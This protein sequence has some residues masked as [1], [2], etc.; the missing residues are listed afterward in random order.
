MTDTEPQVDPLLRAVCADPF[1][2]TLRLAYAD[3]LDEREFRKCESCARPEGRVN[4]VPGHIFVGFGIGWKVCGYCEG[5][6]LIRDTESRK[7]AEHI[8]WAVANPQNSGVCLCGHLG[9]TGT[10]CPSCQMFGTY[11]LARCDRTDGESHYVTHR[12]FVREL[13]ITQLRFIRE[14][15]EIFASEP[16][17]RVNLIDVHVGVPCRFY[18]FP[19][20][21]A[22]DEMTTRSNSHYGDEYVADQ[23]LQLV[24]SHLIRGTTFR[25]GSFTRR[26]RS[27]YHAY[28]G[29]SEACVAFGRRLVGL[30]PLKPVTGVRMPPMHERFDIWPD[31]ER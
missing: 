5:S 16:I 12:G 1:D 17:T 18:S 11:A 3:S 20:S 6:E 28:L 21:M 30:P 27:P 8:R 22:Q 29:L 31:G 4:H 13:R 7:R 2:D 24:P 14:A 26:F 23:I 10:V 25:L 15:K 9:P 19:L